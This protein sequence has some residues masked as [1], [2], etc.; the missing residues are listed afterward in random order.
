MKIYL[1]RHPHG[2]GKGENGDD[3]M[4]QQFF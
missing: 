2:K 3:R 1:D 4:A